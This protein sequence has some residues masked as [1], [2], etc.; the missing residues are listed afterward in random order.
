MKSSG[1]NI[2][3]KNRLVEYMT[4]MI[5]LIA[6]VVGVVLYSGSTSQRNALPETIRDVAM[7]PA[8][9]LQEV[10]LYDHHSQSVELGDFTGHWSLVSFGYTHCPDICPATLAQMA[11][12]YR[13]FRQQQTAVVLP[14]FYFVSVDPRRD[15]ATYL[16]EYTRYFDAS[17][18]GLSGRPNALH[19]F[20]K[21]FGVTHSYVQQANN[22]N[23]IVVHSAKIFLLDPQARIVASF[24]PPMNIKRVAGQYAEFVERYAGR[25]DASEQ[26]AV[27]ITD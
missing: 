17:F 6:V 7:L 13:T 3:S 12:L 21:Q 14:Q 1:K 25:A 9:S 22:D 26:L 18:I 8:V 4:G 24:E 10:N 20:E 23:Y 16:G 19:S 5:A 15:P 2:V 27:K 11:A